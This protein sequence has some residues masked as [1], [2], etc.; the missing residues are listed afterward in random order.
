MR[1]TRGMTRRKLLQVFWVVTLGL[2]SLEFL[3]RAGAFKEVVAGW[4]RPRLDPSSPTGALSDRNRE[5][6]VAF[7]EVLAVGGSLSAL[8]KVSFIEEIDDQTRN[9]P[10][11]LA[12]YRMTANLLDRL[13]QTR[14]S[15]LDIRD[16][17][18]LSVRHRLTSYGVSTR[19]CVFSIQ[20]Q[21]LAVRALAVPDL[22]AAYYRSAAGWAVVGYETF[23]GRCGSLGRYTRAES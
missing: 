13:A 3:R 1:G 7:G 11:Y 4:I 14:F 22:I 8:E 17:T 23:P 19:E 10:G 16:R 6:I 12:L 2:L 9:V 5:T 15:A 20:R 18:D 21:E